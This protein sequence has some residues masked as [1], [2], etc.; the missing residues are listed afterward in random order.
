ME[1]KLLSPFLESALFL[2]K[3]EWEEWQEENWPQQL[4]DL[5][6]FLAL[7]VYLN[8]E[9]KDIGPKQAPPNQWST[10]ERNL[11]DFKSSVIWFYSNLSLFKNFFLSY[12]N[13]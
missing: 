2:S 6:I 12:C 1:L 5:V 8:T 4:A 9:G 11:S 10:F 13:W 7:K 3:C